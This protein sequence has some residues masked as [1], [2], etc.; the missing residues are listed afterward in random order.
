M[1]NKMRG[2]RKDLRVAS[3]KLG[4]PRIQVNFCFCMASMNAVQFARVLAQRNNLLVDR[5][6]SIAQQ[7]WSEKDSRRETTE[8]VA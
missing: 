7:Q 1:A 5:A 2:R 8:E 3:S 6:E 4:P